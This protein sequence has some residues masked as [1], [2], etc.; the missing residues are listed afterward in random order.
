MPKPFTYYP[1]KGVP[2]VEFRPEWLTSPMSIASGGFATLWRA[3]DRGQFAIKCFNNGGMAAAKEEFETLRMLSGERV[4]PKVYGMG[5]FVDGV[6]QGYAAIVE[7]YVDGYTLA[8]ALKRGLLS[9]SARNPVLDTKTA[10]K[11]ALEIARALVRL[12]RVGVSHRDLSANNVMLFRG[13]VERRLAEGVNLVLIDF[14]QSTPIDRSSV[15][16]SDRAR[17]ATVP[18][19]APEMYGGRYWEMR[20]SY[21]CDCWSFGAICVTMLA[22]EY[23]PDEIGDLTHGIA[24][25][26]DLDRIARA[27]ERPLDLEALMRQSNRRVGDVERGL[28][29]V[30]SECTQYNPA[31]RPDAAT[32]V[33]ELERLASRG[34]V[35]PVKEEARFGE[36]E[37]WN[38]K[39][40]NQKHFSTPPFQPPLQPSPEFQI[41]GR[42]LVRYAGKGGEVAVPKGVTAIGAH[43]FRGNEYLQRVLLP[44]TVKV[45]GD[46]AFE[47]CSAL[48]GIAISSVERLG[49]GTFWGCTSLRSIVVR[50]PVREIPWY[51]FR[52]CSSLEWVSLPNSLRSIGRE[53]FAG[54]TALSQV[55]IPRSVM[56]VEARA[57][58]GCTSLD[59]VVVAN[60]ACEIGQDAFKAD[61][62]PGKKTPAALIVATIV[63]VLLVVVALITTFG[64][65]TATHAGESSSNA[66][67][68]SAA[69]TTRL[70]DDEVC[71]IEASRAMGDYEEGRVHFRLEVTNR[72]D[73][74]IDLDVK[75][76]EDGESK[77][78][79]NMRVNGGDKKSGLLWFADEGTGQ[80]YKATIVAYQDDEVLGTYEFD[81]SEVTE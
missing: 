78:N 19:G 18:Y 15:T 10:L 29:K 46:Y 7:E 42:T 48:H 5:T 43:A 36:A 13:C 40:G 21:K 60:P 69:K 31:R 49:I 41:E 9:G 72:M 17:L 3:G 59:R 55:E 51:L 54:C 73:T 81:S 25:Q 71:L 74:R 8:H 27:K 4:V 75:S 6:E 70:A 1:S 11:V 58:Y 38:R 23:W 22:G 16:P 65:C 80:V 32:I 39:D 20:N 28:A 63:A 33:R 50:V 68:T 26:Q 53:S 30:V 79:F 52:E 77:G 67:Q 37:T 47:G 44:E 61:V 76:P 14:G 64:G 2:G 24:S 66:S 57:F 45:I 12:Q 34:R 56:S 62:G 35:R